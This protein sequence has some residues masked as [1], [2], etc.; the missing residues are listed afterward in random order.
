MKRGVGMVASQ[1]I[2]MMRKEKSIPHFKGFMGN[3]KAEDMPRRP[4][5]LFSQWINIELGLDGDQSGYRSWK[6]TQ[7]IGP[8]S[9]R[10]SA[11]RSI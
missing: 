7:S 6:F 3:A 4:A 2:L 9:F 8:D 1:T 10:P 5:G 11:V